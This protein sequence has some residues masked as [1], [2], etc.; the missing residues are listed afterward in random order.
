MNECPHVP[1][2]PRP[3]PEPRSD[4]CPECLAVGSHPVQLRKCLVC[5]HVGCC[6]SSPYQHSTRHFEETGHPV[7]RSFEE[8]E[9]WRW[10]FVDQL[11]VG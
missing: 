5:G 11:I 3:E 1:A 4:T 10:C 8:G 9:D 7:M 6:D 2:L